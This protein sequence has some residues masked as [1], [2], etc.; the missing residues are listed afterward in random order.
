LASSYKILLMI[1]PKSKDFPTHVHYADD[2]FVFCGANRKALTSLMEFLYIYGLINISK[3]LFFAF[4]EFISLNTNIHNIFR[5]NR[6]II[7]FNY[8]SVPIFSSVPHMLFFQPLA[9]RV[10]SKLMSWK[11]K[12]LSLTGRVMLS[13]VSCLIIFRFINGL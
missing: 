5:C 9:D 11:G 10:K 12:S 2:I 6:D 4:N 8:H 1:G 3:S 13:L 7:P